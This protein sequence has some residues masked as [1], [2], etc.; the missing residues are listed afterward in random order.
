[1]K[2]LPA[3]LASLAITLA[4]ALPM[5]FIGLNAMTN[6]NTT[7]TTAVS[8]TLTPGE[9]QTQ[10][11]ATLQAQLAQDRQQIQNYQQVMTQL[12]QVGLVQISSSGTVS[13]NF[14][15]NFTG[16]TQ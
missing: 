13:L 14:N 2:K 8:A 5:L 12:Q 9:T 6:T 4:I 10:Q 15:S 1:M 16:S 7:A 3:I 11:I